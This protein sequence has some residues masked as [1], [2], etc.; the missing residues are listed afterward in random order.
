MIE[1]INT[2]AAPKA[3]GPY[4]Q[5][6]LVN[7]NTLYISGQVGIDPETGELVDT[8]I[9]NQT[10]QVVKN[11]SAILTEAGFTFEN[12]VQTSCFLAYMGDFKKFNH[13]YE[14]YFTSK[15]ARTCV[16]VSDMPKGALLEIA[17]IAVK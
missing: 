2:E 4:S 13:I 6:T 10:E 12:I 15:P 5:A 16:S 11:I 17:V 8:D 7:G 3:V 1:Y 14:K 9:E